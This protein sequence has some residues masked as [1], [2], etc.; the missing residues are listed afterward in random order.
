MLSE[1]VPQMCGQVQD[2]D[3]DRSGNEILRS[4]RT[5]SHAWFVG[6]QLIEEP[7]GLH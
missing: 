4:L 5:S 7:H 3:S 1:S 6:V 2:V